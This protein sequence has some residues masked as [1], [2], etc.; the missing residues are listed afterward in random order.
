M[1]KKDY[2]KGIKLQCYIPEDLDEKLKTEC[3]KYN[4]TR[5]KIV[6]DALYSFIG[7]YPKGIQSINNN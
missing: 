1:I 2:H 5:T 7:E 3:K 4:V 6:T